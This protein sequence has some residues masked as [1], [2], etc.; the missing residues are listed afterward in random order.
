MPELHARAPLILHIATDGRDNWSGALARPNA[1]TSDGPLATLAAARDRLRTLRLADQLTG[2]AEVVVQAGRYEQPATLHFGPDDLGDAEH[3]VLFRAAGDGP[4][5]LTG[6]TRIGNFTHDYG[7]IASADLRA[8]GLAGRRFRQL[9]CN[10]VRQ[11]LARYPSFDPQ[12]PYGGGYL[13]VPGER[14]GV[15]VDGQGAKNQ[16]RCDDTRLVGWS[17]LDEVELVVFP[18]YN[19]FSNTLPLAGYDPATGMVTLGQPASYEIYPGDRFFFRNVAAELDTPGEWYHD[20]ATETLR[21]YPPNSATNVIIELPRVED[22]LVVQGEPER[23]IT[24]ATA[25]WPYWD[26]ELRQFRLPATVGHGYL[27]F[28]DF[29]IE[30]CERHGVVFQG[31]RACRLEGCTIRNTGALGA[32]VIGGADCAIESCDIYETGADGIALTGGQRLPFNGLNHPCDHRALNNYVHHVGIFEKH[33]AGIALNGVGIA[34]TNNLVHDGPRWGI[35]SRG[36]DNRIAYNHLRHL[37]LET[38]DTAGIYMCDRDFTMRGTTIEYNRIHDIL[39]FDYRDGSWRSPSYAF[40]IYLDD[41]TSGVTVRGNLTYRTPRGGIYLHAGQDNVVENNCFL[42]A[43]EELAHFRRWEPPRETR[44]RGTHGQGFR[45]NLVRRNIMATN[46][47]GALAYRFSN[48]A[49]DSGQLDIATNRWEENLIWLGGT[50]PSVSPGTT[51]AGG[52]ERQSWADWC[53]IGFERGSRVAD[54]SFSDP[55]NDDYRLRDDSPARELGFTPL[56]FALMGPQPS[57]LRRVWPLVEAPGAREFPLQTG[58]TDAV[59]G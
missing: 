43:T 39:G 29:I 4:V 6:S 3:P 15:Y 22:L 21:F 41:W 55:A 16:F 27:T 10:G 56:P 31:S 58:I 17:R 5:H 33:V 34:V 42:D 20:R 11:Q 26:D 57:L 24:L 48:A 2:A 25:R 37:N 13:Y 46:A 14:G 47:P 23:P 7:P 35:I 40:G 53:A 52:P 49:D 28:R 9:F 18:R 32:F 54:P 12:N 59:S 19:Y 1:N 44:M 30:G 36:N 50:E 51:Y 38:A 8:A 45:R